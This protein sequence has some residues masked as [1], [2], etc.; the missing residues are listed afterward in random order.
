MHRPLVGARIALVL[1]LAIALVPAGAV[2]A[3]YERG[4][5]TAHTRPTHIHTGRCPVPGPIVGPLSDV[6]P[7]VGVTVGAPG[8]IVV[9]SSRSTSDWTL[10]ELVASD[11]VVA[12]HLSYDQMETIIACGDIGGPMRSATELVI[13]LGPVGGSGY[14]GIAVIADTGGGMSVAD[15]YITMSA[16]AA[17]PGASPAPYSP[18]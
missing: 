9:E 1:A 12:V 17:S 8:A 14:S 18:Y 13:G 15:V 4:G 2:I 5:S 16:P 11:H 6:A 3:Q 10:S 7:S